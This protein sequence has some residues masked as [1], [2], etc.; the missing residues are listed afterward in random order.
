MHNHFCEFFFPKSAWSV[1]PGLQ[2]NRKTCPILPLVFASFSS[3]N[4]CKKLGF[5]SRVFRSSFVEQK[6]Q[7]Q[8]KSLIFGELTGRYIINTDLDCFHSFAHCWKKICLGQDNFLRS[9]E[10]SVLTSESIRCAVVRGFCLVF[11]VKTKS[12][13]IS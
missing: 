8:R 2:C 3:Y 1:A 10:G 9:N 7:S 13:S 5:P 4:V 6:T 12:C 11:E